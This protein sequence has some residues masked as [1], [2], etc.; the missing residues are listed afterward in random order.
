MLGKGRKFLSQREIL[1][2][3]SGMMNRSRDS[4][5]G[6]SAEQIGAAIGAGSDCLR[7][8]NVNAPI[9]EDNESSHGVIDITL[10]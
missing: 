6:A 5:F 9:V 7:R 4:F 1:L 2:G 8:H 3:Q 10:Q